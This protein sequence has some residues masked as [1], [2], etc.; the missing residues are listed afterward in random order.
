M[1]Q[2]NVVMVTGASS[3]FGNLT[4]RALAQAGHIVYAGMRATTTRNV[5]A[6]AALAQVAKD[7]GVRMAAVE[8]DVQE[9]IRSTPPSIR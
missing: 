8:M 3:G 5:S 1:T 4:A 2:P 9:R 7:R 6:V